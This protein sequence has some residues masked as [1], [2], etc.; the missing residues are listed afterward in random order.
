MR[1]LRFD[2]VTRFLAEARPRRAAA[3][4]LLTGV[5]GLSRPWKVAARKGKSKK[6]KTKKPRKPITPPIPPPTGCPAERVCGPGCC[7]QGQVCG[8]NGAC[9]HPSCCSGPA[10]CGSH[11]SVGHVCCVAP[12]QARC[13]CDS[14]RGAQNGY[15]HCC[16]GAECDAACPSGGAIAIGGLVGPP[17]A[18]GICPNDGFAVAGCAT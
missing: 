10:I 16:L 3:G 6:P 2:T 17:N 18:A 5:L 15:V 11:T 13:C 1:G 9:V 4:L 14:P 12:R 7:P 8:S